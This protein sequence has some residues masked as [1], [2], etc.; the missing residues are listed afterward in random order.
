MDKIV[1]LTKFFLN[2]PLPRQLVLNRIICDIMIN[3][4]IYNN[5]Q[6]NFIVFTMRLPDTAAVMVG[7]KIY[8]EC[9]LQNPTHTVRWFQN[10]REVTGNKRYNAGQDG[11]L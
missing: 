8:L 6:N 4:I 9:E 2:L 11:I 5:L 7:E 10:G 1:P 3:R